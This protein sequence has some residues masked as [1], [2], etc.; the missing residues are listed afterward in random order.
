MSVKTFTV[1]ELPY[2]YTALAPAISESIMRLHRDTHHVAYV[3]K[4]NAALEDVGYPFSLAASTDETDT[5]ALESLLGSLESLPEAIRTAVRNNGG[6]HY[7]H[8][9][10]W[11]CMTP[12]QQQGAMS[13][14]L[15]MALEERYGSIDA[16]KTAF[17]EKALG[18][19][20]SGWVWLQPNLDIVTTANQD[21]PIM[22]G[23]PSPILGLDVWEHAYYLDYKAAR[24]DYVD[25][26]WGV[27]SWEFVSTQ[28]NQR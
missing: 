16:F 4:L 1:P 13:E 8:S 27:V 17:L 28:Y 7:N 5:Q 9:F 10:F 12:S 25:A 18:L 14:E 11:E 24:K 2:A 22:N 15:R 23:E 19:F 21:N 20:G 6:G 26:W 3:T